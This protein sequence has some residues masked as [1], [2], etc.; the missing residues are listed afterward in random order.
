MECIS[1][2]KGYKYQLTQ[3]YSLTIDILP[4][5]FIESPSGFI[6]L[7]KQGLLTINNGYAWDGPS[8]PTIDT[9]NFMRASL[10]HDA[11]YQLMREQLLD[12]QSTRKRADK[13]LQQLC[14]Q[15]GMSALRA[16]LAYSGLRLLGSKA[17]SPLNKKSANNAPSTC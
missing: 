6:S 16:W 5:Q 4:E 13:L 3:S 11:L 10:V 15:D 7:S 17:A 8:G 9:Q 1:Y 14:R 2:K 12:T